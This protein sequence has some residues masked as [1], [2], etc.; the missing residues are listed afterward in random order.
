MRGGFI[1]C[2]ISPNVGNMHRENDKSVQNFD[3]KIGME[4]TTCGGVVCVDE[5]IVLLWT[6]EE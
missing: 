4:E 1:N 2:L 5:S 3:W 6:L